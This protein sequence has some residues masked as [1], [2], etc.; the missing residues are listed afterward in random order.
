MTVATPEHAPS[1][2][3][4]ALSWDTAAFAAQCGLAALVHHARIGST[5]DEAHRLAHAGAAAGTL[6]VA[7]AQD[8]GRGR[9]GRSWSSE[10]E[11]GLWM[12]LIERPRD[13]AAIDVLAL[14]IGMALADALAPYSDG[15]IA[16]KWP[17]DLYVGAGKLAGILR[18]S[19]HTH[20][21]ATN[22]TSWMGRSRS[23]RRWETTKERWCSKPHNHHSFQFE[24]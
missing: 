12:T 14:R 19:S 13:L 16:L 11:A 17:N 9:G 18:T 7:D 1:A 20:G 23:V 22:G 4:S 6:V 8:G 2:S 3:P 15:A 10:P 24:L 21:N 5:M